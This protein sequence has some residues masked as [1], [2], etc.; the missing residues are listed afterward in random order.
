MAKGNPWH[1]KT[2]KVGDWTA[3]CDRSGFRGHA[4]KMVTTWDGYFVLESWDEERTPQ[5]FVRAVQ[6]QKAL[7]PSMVRP[8]DEDED[9]TDG[10]NTEQSLI[11][12][13][14]ARG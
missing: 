10:T 9:F 12:E 3:I 11:D 6:D 2:Q 5:D 13:L 4:S 14:L 7:P 8:K 1:N